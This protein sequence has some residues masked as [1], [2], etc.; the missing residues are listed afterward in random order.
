[1]MPTFCKTT[2]FK[3]SRIGTNGDYPSYHLCTKSAPVIVTRS[4]YKRINCFCQLTI[5][6]SLQYHHDHKKNMDRKATSVIT[7]ILGTSFIALMLRC[8]FKLLVFQVCLPALSF[9]FIFKH[10]MKS[11]TYFKPYSTTFTSFTVNIKTVTIITRH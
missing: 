5:S 8:V 2:L 4:F 9:P 6:P 7:T 10:L 1:M 11:K 3:T